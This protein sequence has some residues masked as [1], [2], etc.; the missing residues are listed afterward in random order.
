MLLKDFYEVRKID[1]SQESDYTAHISLNK[2]HGIFKGHFPDR[3]IAPGVCMLQII[4][5]ITSEILG[6]KLSLVSTGDI[7]FLA[8]INPQNHP[9]LQLSIQITQNQDRSVTVKNI[10]S[11]GCTVALK[12]SAT[13]ETGPEIVSI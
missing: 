8:I 4:K 13:Y 12:M 7:K 11:F 1:I 6:K 10:T 5:N 2:D 9:D 3:P